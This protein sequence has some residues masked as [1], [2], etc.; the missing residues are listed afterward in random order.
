MPGRMLFRYT[1][2]EVDKHNTVDDLWVIHNN[3]VYDVTEFVADHPGGAELI[4]KWAG[5]DI[6]N[7]L[8][9]PELHDHSEVAYEAL[10]ELC[11]GDIVDS[12]N[13]TT[14]A[15]PPPSPPQ[16]AEKYT[17][18]DKFHPTTTNI[19]SDLKENFLDLNKPLFHQMFNCDFSKE[20]YLKQIHKPRHLPYSV[21]LFENPF[22]ELL[23]KTPWYVI[24]ILWLPVVYYH[25]HIASEYLGTKTITVLFIIGIWIWT[26]L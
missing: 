10:A 15:T 9:N 26:L 19:K 5:K 2:E 17:L 18:V 3:K 1:C 22:L 16:C 13:S 6:T 20:F 11:I 12:N 24:P 4:I 23:T 8:N 14:K 25:A 21:K 7:V